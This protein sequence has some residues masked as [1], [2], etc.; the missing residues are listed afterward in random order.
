MTAKYIHIRGL[1]GNSL[2]LLLILA[3]LLAATSG[4]TEGRASKDKPSPG[5]QVTANKQVQRPAR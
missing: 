2:G 3:M 1:F 4:E 5:Q